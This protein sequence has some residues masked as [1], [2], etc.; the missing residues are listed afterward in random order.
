MVN[1]WPVNVNALRKINRYL[2]IKHI[3]L[4]FDPAR[5]LLVPPTHTL[6]K[7]EYVNPRNYLPNCR[8]IQFWLLSRHGTRF[9]DKS[10]ISAMQH[11]PDLRDQILNN[12]EKRRKGRL[13]HKDLDN[14]RSWSL[15]VFPSQASELTNQGYDD[16][17]FMARRFKTKFPTLLQQTYSPDLF[18]F[19]FTDSQRTKASATAFADGL[20][21]SS[22]GVN[23][24]QPLQNDTLIKPYDSCPKWKKEVGNNNRTLEEKHLFEMGPLMQALVQ[25]VSERLGFSYKLTYVQMDQMYDMCRF[26]KAWNI[27]S[28]SPWCAAF[29]K[30]ELQ[31]LE[32]R[33]DLE[34]YY[35]AGYGN[36][37][38]IKLGCT[39]VRDMINHFSQLE[40]RNHRDNI[41]PAGIFYFTHS[42]AI[43]MTLAQ[44]GIAK[45]SEHLTH[46]N[47]NSMRNRK[48]KTSDIAPFASNLAAVFFKCEMEEMHRV[49]FYLGEHLVRYEGCN[50]GLCS[51]SYIKD[52]FAN[53]ASQCNLDFCSLDGSG[54][55]RQLAISWLTASAFVVVSVCRQFVI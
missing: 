34:Y 20:F 11:L 21:G 9:P 39:T 33:E 54:S 53:V 44:L 50:V 47:Y 15:S 43:Q 10:D 17:K 25:N 45:D 19:R 48:W 7:F 31:L 24:P 22:S 26:D 35:H 12:H 27:R 5:C 23:F 3:N 13:C 1:D 14:L 52:K 36:D 2:S 40:D 6:P 18:E 55:H 42:S 37:I 32:Y 46:S 8:P 28:T 16:L 4:T 49:I 29:S 30:E 41:Q 38:N 51:W